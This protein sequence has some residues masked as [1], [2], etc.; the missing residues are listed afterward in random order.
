[1]RPNSITQ[2]LYYYFFKNMP[3]KSIGHVQYVISVLLRLQNLAGAQLLQTCRSKSSVGVVQ[4]VLIFC[5]L[6]QFCE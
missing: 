2:T 4:I 3:F 6:Q 5:M 1:M